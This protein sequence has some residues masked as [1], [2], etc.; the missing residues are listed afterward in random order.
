MPSHSQIAPISGRAGII[1]L[2]LAALALL[3]SSGPSVRADE[4]A[5]ESPDAEFLTKLVPNIAASVQII[6][7]EIKHTSDE[8]VKEFAQR[9]L[10][11]HAGSV[12]T[13]T[14]HAKRLKV[15]VDTKGDE[16]AKEMLDKLSKL[17]GTD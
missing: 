4:K 10:D 17:K 12:K 9:V 15:D 11:Q 14:G 8:K 16:E 5:K 1:A 2:A 13:A 7:Y 3:L 6:K